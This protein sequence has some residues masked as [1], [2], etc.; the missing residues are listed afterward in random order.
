[1]NQT[2]T[3]TSQSQ[4]E[5][6]NKWQLTNFNPYNIE[7]EVEVSGEE[8]FTKE[9]FESVLKTVSSKTSEPVAETI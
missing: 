9:H 4:A 8:T 5:Q 3:V 2:I 1:M 7:K 6:L